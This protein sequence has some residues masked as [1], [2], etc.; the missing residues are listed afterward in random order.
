MITAEQMSIN[1]DNVII[2][3]EQDIVKEGQFEENKSE[4]NSS[5]EMRSKSRSKREK[6]IPDRSIVNFKAVYKEH[7]SQHSQSTS[8]KRQDQKAK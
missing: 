6:G 3:D 4:V 5:P 8:R 1:E 7:H 2:K